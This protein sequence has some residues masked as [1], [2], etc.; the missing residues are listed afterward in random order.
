MFRDD[1]EEQDFR[2]IPTVQPERWE[3]FVIFRETFLI[4]V[5]DPEANK[6]VR[7]F[8]KVLFSGVL[9]DGRVW[10]FSYMDW[11]ED[12]LWAALADLRQLQGFVKFASDR[13]ATYEGDEEEIQRHNRLYRIGRN[14]FEKLGA[15]A[16]EFE[17]QLTAEESGTGARKEE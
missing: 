8:G 13:E 3:D 16:D 7:A 11:T 10:P 4:N 1:S 14:L 5:Q 2:E 15:L 6:A 12:E 9:A 17:K